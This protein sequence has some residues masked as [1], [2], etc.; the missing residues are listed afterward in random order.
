MANLLPAGYMYQGHALLVADRLS[1]CVF[2]DVMSQIAIGY[3]LL[4]YEALTI[5]IHSLCYTA[6]FCLTMKRLISHDH[7]GFSMIVDKMC[8]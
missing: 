8:R 5:K 6:V 3:L 7:G 4:Q 1:I 2:Y